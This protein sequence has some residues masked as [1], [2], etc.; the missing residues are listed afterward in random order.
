MGNF[1]PTYASIED[2]WCL[3][4]DQGRNPPLENCSGTLHFREEIIRFAFAGRALSSRLDFRGFWNTEKAFPRRIPRKKTS[5]LL[6]QD[7][8]ELYWQAIKWSEK[9]KALLAKAEQPVIGA[10]YQS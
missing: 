4:A 2:A 10:T 9:A 5:I 6:R 3:S 7:F 8:S 1:V